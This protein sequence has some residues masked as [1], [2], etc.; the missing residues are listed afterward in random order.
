MD[1]TRNGQGQETETKR[2]GTE[3][4]RKTNGKGNQKNREK[5]AKGKEEERKRKGTEKRKRGKAK[6]R[7]RKGKGK[8]RER[9]GKEWERRKGQFPFRLLHAR[10]FVQNTFTR[11]RSLYGTSAIAAESACLAY[12]HGWHRRWTTTRFPVRILQRSCA[13]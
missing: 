5:N 1:R 4:E 12:L 9:K 8:E 10:N 13:H 2:K 6:E 7:H 3:E 11:G